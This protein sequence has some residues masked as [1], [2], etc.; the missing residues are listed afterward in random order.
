MLYGLAE[1]FSW[2]CLDPADPSPQA[3]S[4]SFA[5][6]FPSSRKKGVHK[7]VSNTKCRY[8]DE[9]T[10]N[11]PI[12]AA[13]ESFINPTL[14]NVGCN[15]AWLPAPAAA[16]IG[17]CVD[18]GKIIISVA[19]HDVKVA[20]TK[21]M[22]CEAAL[23]LP[24]VRRV[25]TLRRSHMFSTY[26]RRIRFLTTETTYVSYVLYVNRECKCILHIKQTGIFK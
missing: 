7:N 10:I 15:E 6:C 2:K 17:N 8:S 26:E 24:P 5:Y 25:F 9:T 21:I 18:E 13:T 12:P 11:L 1:T 3:Q 20:T 22:K 16:T 19:I 14:L 4:L 23:L